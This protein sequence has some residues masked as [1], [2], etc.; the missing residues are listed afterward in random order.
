MS[1]HLELQK[2]NA[3]L[4]AYRALG[5]P[6]DARW[7]IRPR[8]RRSSAVLTLGCALCQAGA[9]KEA[10]SPAGMAR[11]EG[12]ALAFADCPHLAPLLQP[13]PPELAALLDLELLAGA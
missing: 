6:V 1:L 4:R 10:W 9:M 5:V 3:R 7:E 2:R 8:G 12:E 13:D 11:A